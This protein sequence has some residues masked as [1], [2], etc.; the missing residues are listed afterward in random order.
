MLQLCE[1]S[2]IH[3]YCE[4]NKTFSTKQEDIGTD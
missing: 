3:G 2:H 1:E 4:K